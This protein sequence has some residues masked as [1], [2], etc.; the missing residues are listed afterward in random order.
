MIL[1]TEAI[2]VGIGVVATTVVVGALVVWAYS[3][4]L[5]SDMFWQVIL[6]LTSIG[7]IQASAW[8]DGLTSNTTC[9]SEEGL[10]LS[11]TT[12][13]PD[14]R[15]RIEKS[16]FTKIVSREAPYDTM[17]ASA[18]IRLLC[19]T[20]GVAVTVCG[21]TVVLSLVSLS[22]RMACRRRLDFVRTAVSSF[23]IGFIARVISFAGATILNLNSILVSKSLEVVV[24]VV[25]LV[26]VV[27]VGH[28]PQLTAHCFFA[29]SSCLQ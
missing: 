16:S 21:F 4:G 17:F 3:V 6:L 2:V 28:T 5:N 15:S 22:M 10:D 12:I 18:S 1:V 29:K 13:S 19:R 9:T 14:S 27:V 8:A 24:V 20:K 26:V 7:S 23:W 25:V 11:L